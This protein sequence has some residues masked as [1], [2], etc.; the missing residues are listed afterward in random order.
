MLPIG[1]T[2]EARRAVGPSA[3]AGGWLLRG[4]WPI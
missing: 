1:I 4:I 2:F 3:L